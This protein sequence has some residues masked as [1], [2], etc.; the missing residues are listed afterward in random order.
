MKLYLAEGRFLLSSE[1]TLV[2]SSGLFLKSLHYKFGMWSLRDVVFCIQ[3]ESNV[4]LHY[5]ICR[6]QCFEAYGISLNTAYS[7]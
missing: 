4:T 3:G 7:L 6:I 1:I 5:G 2:M